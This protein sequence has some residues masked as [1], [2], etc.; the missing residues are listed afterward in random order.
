MIVAMMAPHGDLE[1]K[2]VDEDAGET[3]LRRGGQSVSGR[4][5]APAKSHQDTEAPGLPKGVSALPGE[6]GERHRGGTNSNGPQH[7]A[8]GRQVQ[9]RVP[10]AN[11]PGDAD[12]NWG[13][14]GVAK[15][16]GRKRIIRSTLFP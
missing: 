6:D 13:R 9:M 2:R 4:V 11:P 10:L 16:R 12:G 5:S 7:V 1:K 8:R 15:G 3:N 14:G